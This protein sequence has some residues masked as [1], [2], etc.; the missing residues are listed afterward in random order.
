VVA[1]YQINIGAPYAL[2]LVG[3]GAG[4]WGAGPWGVGVESTGQMRIWS[5]AN[6]GE[7]LLFAPN[8]GEIYVWKA[9]SLLTSRGVAI[10][11][12]SGASSCP[13]VQSSI[14]VSDA[15]RFTFA[16][17]CN[18]YGSTIQNPML[19]RWS[20]QEDYLEW[21]PS[22]TNQAG[23][24]Q[25]SHGSKIVTAIQTRQEIV[26]FTD[27]ALYSLQYQGPPAVWGSQLLGDN[28]SIAGTNAAA[29]ATGVVYWMGIDKFYKYDGRCMF[30]Q[31]LEQAHTL[32]PYQTA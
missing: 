22:A 9:S 20:D 27:S 7:D 16:F 17:G 30:Y 15:S 28:T 3:W 2:P 13:T 23:S 11:N 5:Q 10:N 1:A 25:L 21:F 31:S 8:G 4:P 32:E 12:L 18:D 24:L 14:L 19:I 6:F 29:T 26:V